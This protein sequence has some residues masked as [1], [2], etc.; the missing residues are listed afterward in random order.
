MVVVMVL[1]RVITYVSFYQ[2]P[3]TILSYLHIG[4]YLIP[5]A[6][7]WERHYDY[8]RFTEEEIEAQ[9]IKK[10]KKLDQDHRASKY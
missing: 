3:G 7:I 8:S 9:K 5:I 10:K 6:V 1:V 2:L 4:V